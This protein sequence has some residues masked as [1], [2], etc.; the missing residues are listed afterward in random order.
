MTASPH[1]P[2]IVILP[3]C[4]ELHGLPLFRLADSR[5]LAACERWCMYRIESG[6][7]V[8]VEQV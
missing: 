4:C 7:L 3:G 1:A 2:A 6:E 5:T 8:K